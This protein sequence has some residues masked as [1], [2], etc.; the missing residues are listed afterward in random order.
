VRELLAAYREQEDL[1]TIGAYRPGSNPAVDAALAMREAIQQFLRQGI[2]ETCDLETARQA[3]LA[4]G[5]ACQAARK[6][7]PA[8]ASAPKAAR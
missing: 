5:A 6:S 4:L 7:P 8:A 3:L 1:I 2:H